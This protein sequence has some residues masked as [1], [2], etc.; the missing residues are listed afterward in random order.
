MKSNKSDNND[1]DNDKNNN[2]DE[3][4]DNI[5][6]V[7]NTS[8]NSGYCHFNESGN[9]KTFTINLFGN[10]V[11]IEQDPSSTI[12][13]GASVWDSSVIF[14]K[15]VEN[16]PSIFSPSTISGKSCIELGSGTGL[17]GISLMMLGAKV[18]FTD[19]PDVIEQFTISNANRIYN[20]MKSKG[21]GYLKDIHEPIIRPL[22]WTWDD[23]Q[24]KETITNSPYDIVLLTDCVFSTYLVPFLVRTILKCTG[25]KTQIICSHEIRDEDANNAFKLALKQHYQVKRIAFNKLHQDYKN[26]FVELLLAKASRK[27]SSE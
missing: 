18:T 10:D 3:E 16:N 2:N 11:V 14:S 26:M 19:L 9:D 7:G 12:G 21:S 4:D 17:A 24:Q 13:H 8:S 25:P 6:G 5:N 1:N 20:Q 27:K 22:D 23:N 15:Y